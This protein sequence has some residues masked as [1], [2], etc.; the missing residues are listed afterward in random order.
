MPVWLTNRVRP[1]MTHSQ[2]LGPLHQRRSY[3]KM[4]K[5][6]IQTSEAQGY[7]Q[8]SQASSSSVL[9]VLTEAQCVRTTRQQEH[10]C[11]GSLYGEP[12]TATA[13]QTHHSSTAPQHQGPQTLPPGLHG[14]WDSLPFQAELVSTPYLVRLTPVRQ[15]GPHSPPNKAPGL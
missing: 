9:S 13:P 4:P 1:C 8:A 10:V 3:F 11:T 5:A 12:R 6:K 2:I 15:K 14:D 7:P